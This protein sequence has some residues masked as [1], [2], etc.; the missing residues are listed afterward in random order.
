MYNMKETRLS[1][2]GREPYEKYVVRVVREMNAER[3]SEKG[4]KKLMDCK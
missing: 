3:N 4:K 1:R 2:Y